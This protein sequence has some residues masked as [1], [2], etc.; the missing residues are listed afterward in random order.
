M[1]PLSKNISTATAVTIAPAAIGAHHAPLTRSRSH[2]PSNSGAAAT[3][4]YIAPMTAS[5]S[6]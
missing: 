1:T 2:A 4:K 3:P 6:W 5:G